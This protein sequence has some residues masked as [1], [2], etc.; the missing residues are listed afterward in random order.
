MGSPNDGK[1]L[2]TSDDAEEGFV[3]EADVEYPDELHL[4]YVLGCLVLESSMDAGHRPLC[5]PL[6]YRHLFV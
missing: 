5:P 3:V 1:V 4:L 2:E 6:F